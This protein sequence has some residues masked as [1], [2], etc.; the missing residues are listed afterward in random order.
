MFVAGLN[1]G[2]TGPTSVDSTSGWFKTETTVE[3]IQAFKE[4]IRNL[5]LNWERMDGNY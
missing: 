2:F 1:A 3:N 5:V 4:E